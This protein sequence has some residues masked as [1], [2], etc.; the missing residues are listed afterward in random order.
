MHNL[1]FG[2]APTTMML[3]D[4]S[5]SDALGE[6]LLLFFC[7]QEEENT[8]AIYAV[9][10]SVYFLMSLSTPTTS[11]QIRVWPFNCFCNM[12]M[13]MCLVLT[14]C[15]SLSQNINYVTRVIART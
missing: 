15:K 10:L 4:L 13:T 6:L 8:A 5:A 9:Y 12:T 11:A 3:C 14:L 2:P 7:S 1:V